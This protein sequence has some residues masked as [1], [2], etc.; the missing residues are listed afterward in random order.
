MPFPGMG[1]LNAKYEDPI[2]GYNIYIYIYIKSGQY[3]EWIILT[4]L[5]GVKQLNLRQIHQRLNA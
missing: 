1:I 4:I 2:Y 5:I 3:L